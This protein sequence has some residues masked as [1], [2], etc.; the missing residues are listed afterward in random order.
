M[1]IEHRMDVI[2]QSEKR[3]DVNGAKTALAGQMN[4]ASN[5]GRVFT[6]ELIGIVCSANNLSRAYKQVK[7]EQEG[8]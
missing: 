7:K 6:E 3:K 8:P 4:K 1:F 5:Q 2:C